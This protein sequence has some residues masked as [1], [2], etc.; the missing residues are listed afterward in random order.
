MRTYYVLSCYDMP[1]L[2]P[3]LLPS[4]FFYFYFC[5]KQSS[6]ARSIKTIREIIIIIKIIIMSFNVQRVGDDE[7]EEGEFSP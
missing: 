7:E 1:L 2:A 3:L 4:L 5:I 6:Y